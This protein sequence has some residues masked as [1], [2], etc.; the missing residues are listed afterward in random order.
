MTGKQESDGV[1][2]CLSWEWLPISD[3]YFMNGT[4]LMSHYTVR[5]ELVGGRGRCSEV[6]EQKTFLL[7]STQEMLVF[8][9]VSGAG[10]EG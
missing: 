5:A 1:G 6:T 3:G 9:K 2:F 8:L 10:T 7:W 4:A